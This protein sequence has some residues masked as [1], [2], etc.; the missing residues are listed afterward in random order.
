MEA[1]AAAARP[2]LRL[3]PGRRRLRA[4]CWQA[5]LARAQAAMLAL[6]RAACRA[7]ACSTSPAAPGWSRSPRRSA[8]GAARAG[9]RRRPLR[10]DGRRGAQARR[11]RTASPTPASRAWTPRRSSSPTPASTS[12]LC[13]L[14]LMYMPD[15]ARAV[16]EMRRVLRPGGRSA[17]A[18]W[19]ERS[20]CGWSPVFAIV[21]AEVASEVCPLFFRLGPARTRWRGCA[22]DGGLRA[23]SRSA[24][25]RRRSH[26]ADGDEACDAAFV[27][28]P[29]R[30]GLVALRRRGARA[31]S[32]R[33]IWRRSRRWRGRT[34]AIASRPSSSSPSPRARIRRPDR[35]A[36]RHRPRARRRRRLHRQQQRAE[37][38]GDQRA[39][40]AD[41]EGEAIAG[42]ERRD[43]GWR[44]RALAAPV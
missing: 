29:G 4:R 12:A 35:H 6:R 23:P 37:P 40:R 17:L 5:Q 39:D 22:R 24:A 31:R 32:R 9:A 14:G 20:R 33:A 28:G 43:L 27:G 11:R 21:D 15:P 44:R 8:V 36:R 34:A 42:V 25:S 41:A 26:Y 16:R 2:A 38:G 1:Q 7:S 30:A 3:G 18:V 19:G 10:R 13:A